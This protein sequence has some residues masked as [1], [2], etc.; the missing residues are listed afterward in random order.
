MTNQYY[1]PTT[2]STYSPKNC[3]LVAASQLLTGDDCY[4]VAGFKQW[5]DTGRCVSKGQHGTHIYMF[6]DKKIKTPDGD[7]EKKKVC[8]QRT[9]FF[10]SQTSELESQAA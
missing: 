3:A 5:L 6:C 4:E 9:V 8:K 2:G 1:N 7:E 10:K